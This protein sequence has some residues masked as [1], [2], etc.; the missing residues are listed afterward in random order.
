MSDNDRATVTAGLANDVEAVNLASAAIL[1]G[2]H[3]TRDDLPLLARHAADDRRYLTVLDL[4]P[5]TDLTFG[6]P[7]VKDGRDLFCQ[8]REHRQS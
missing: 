8:V 5:G 7:P 1:V 4:P 6:F 3:G 2:L